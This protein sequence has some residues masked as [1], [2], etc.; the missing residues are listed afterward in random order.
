[1]NSNTIETYYHF[2]Q[3]ERV[4]T[5]EEAAKLNEEN[6]WLSV[7]PPDIW[8]RVFSHFTTSPKDLA[9]CRLVCKTFNAI[10]VSNEMQITMRGV[11]PNYIIAIDVSGSMEPT[12]TAGGRLHTAVLQV[13]RIAE[14]TLPIAHRG[15]GIIC[16]AEDQSSSDVHNMEELEDA[17]A[18]RTQRLGG[19]LIDQVISNIFEAHRSQEQP[20]ETHVHLFSDFEVAVSD[21]LRGELEFF[22][23]EKEILPLF[24]RCY[25]CADTALSQTFLTTLKEAGSTEGTLRVEVVREEP[26]QSDEEVED[27]AEE[28]EGIGDIF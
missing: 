18:Q 27:S 11:C 26:V 19:T 1:M 25:P 9:S 22:G 20:R 21:E 23:T 6:E 8:L 12:R 5:P 16:F 10:I 3:A 2:V 7:M 14:R 15:I 28:E 13:R 4:Y 17:I 24:L